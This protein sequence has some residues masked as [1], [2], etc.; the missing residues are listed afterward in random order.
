[1]KQQRILV[2][3]AVFAI[4]PQFK[5]GIVIAADLCNPATVPEL[6]LLLNQTVALRR[7]QRNLEHPR[8]LDWEAIHRSF[9]SNPNKFPPSI[10]SLLKRV[11]SG[12][13]LPFINAVVAIFNTVSLKYLIPCGGDDL[14]SI[15]GDLR[16]DCA[17][18]DESFTALGADKPD[19]PKPGEVVYFD[20]ATRQVMCR[21]WNWRNGDFSKIRPDTRRMVINLDG[22]PS[23]PGTVI[24]QATA[25]LSSLLQR[26]CAARTVV[27]LLDNGQRSFTLP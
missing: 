4:S 21:R 6:Q 15:G 19:P 11:E 22:G 7:S 24:A 5:R 17:R 18:G 26:F 16:L 10:K 12:A 27:G 2:S 20:D 8:L 13:E 23:T 1:M 25:E 14:D 3:A 9:G